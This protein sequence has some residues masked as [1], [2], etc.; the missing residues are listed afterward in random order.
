MTASRV[1]AMMRELT[2]HNEKAAAARAMSA[3]ELMTSY[4]LTADETDAI[5]GRRL[6]V[7]HSM[8]VHEVTLMQFSRTFQFSIAERW[9]ELAK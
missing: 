3:E 9:L 6:D 5:V 7:L 1:T 4:G 8:G 2:L